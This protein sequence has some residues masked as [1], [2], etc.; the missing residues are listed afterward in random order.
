MQKTIQITESNS[1]QLPPSPSSDTSSV[2]LANKCIAGLI[3]LIEIYLVIQAMLKKVFSI[4]LIQILTS[5][6]IL[7]A[8]FYA[9]LIFGGDAQEIENEGRYQANQKYIQ[10]VESKN[11]EGI[12][13]SK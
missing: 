6:T 12:Y 4:R 5:F 3:F 9:F 11:P 1:D 8:L 13:I 2:N 10:L 7:T